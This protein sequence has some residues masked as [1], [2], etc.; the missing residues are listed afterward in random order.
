MTLTSVLTL[1]VCVP[2]VDVGVDFWSCTTREP[3]CA[4]QDT[5]T[6]LFLVVSTSLT[7]SDEQN[8]P[9]CPWCSFSSCS[10]SCCC[11]LLVLLLLLLLTFV[12]RV[13]VAE[14]QQWNCFSLVSFTTNHVHT[15]FLTRFQISRLHHIPPSS[16]ISFGIPPSLFAYNAGSNIDMSLYSLS[17]G[18][19]QVFSTEDPRPYT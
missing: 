5:S 17:L 7:S 13:N 3:W 2:C 8:M 18:V 1:Y 9:Y 15:F 10:S 14:L 6:R 12:W 16:S 19:I 11:R 4:F